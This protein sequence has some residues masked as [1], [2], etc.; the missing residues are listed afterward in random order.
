MKKLLFMCVVSFVFFIG[1]GTV[2]QYKKNESNFTPGM[3]KTTIVKNQTTQTEILSVFGSPNIVT[4]NK[5]GNEVW[6]YDNVAIESTYS[7]AGIG[8]LGG[9]LIDKVV[10]GG[11][12]GVESGR[13]SSSSRTFTLMIEFGE[14]EIVKDFSYRSSKF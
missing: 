5:T 13:S 10:V 8:G 4:K 9:G 11:V 3:V 1:C 14:D 6:T 12:V 7:Q 2:K